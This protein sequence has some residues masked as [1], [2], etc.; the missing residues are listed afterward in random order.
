MGIDRKL[1]KT[2]P[3]RSYRKYVK[4]FTGN[5]YTSD[6]CTKRTSTAAAKLKNALDFAVTV[7]QTAV[8][9]FTHWSVFT[10]LENNV[11]CK[12]YKKDIFFC[13]TNG[14]GVGFKIV[15]NCQ[16]PDSVHI[17]PFPKISSGYEINRRFIYVMRFLGVGL[18]SVRNFC[19]IM[20]IKKN[21]FS[22]SG[23]YD[24]MNKIYI[25][26][27]LLLRMF[28]KKQQRISNKKNKENNEPEDRLS[29][30]GD[31]SW[32]KIGF[33]AL[34]GLVSVIGKYSNKIIDVVVRSKIC[35]ICKACKYPQGSVEFEVWHAKHIKKMNV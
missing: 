14:K 30:S 32:P 24:C 1:N 18:N 20:D 16:C 10:S 6:E 29:V 26:V 2:A 27:S 28:L 17:L 31:G 13:K 21:A 4:Q 25:A 23:Y 15:I 33:A 22:K 34:L 19:G 11:F 35:H 5:R 9:S 8:Y 7:F 3:K 12:R